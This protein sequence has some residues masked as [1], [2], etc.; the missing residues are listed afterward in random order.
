MPVEKAFEVTF[1]YFQISSYSGS[2]TKAHFSAHHNLTLDENC[3]YEC[4]YL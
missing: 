1:I 4:R 3:L 2:Y